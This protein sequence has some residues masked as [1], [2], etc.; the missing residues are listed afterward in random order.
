M[1]VTKVFSIP[2]F[3]QSLRA[4]RVLLIA[5]TVVLCL[6]TIVITYAGNLIAGTESTDYTDAQTDFYSHL[7]VL[8]AYNEMMGTDLS[9]EDFASS[10]DTT[11]YETVFEMMSAQSEDLD[12]SVEK[13]AESAELLSESDVGLDVYITNFEY[14]YALGATEGVFT[15]DTL[16]VSTMMTNMFEMMGMSSDMLTTMTEMDTSAMLNQMYFTIMCLLPII[17]FIIFAGNELFVDQ[18][19]KGSMA[20][21]L[22]TPTKR[23][24]VV[25]TQLIY[26]IITP[27]IMVGCGFLV[28][29]AAT[30]AFAGEVDIAKYAA[31]YGG[32]YLLAEAM[33]SIC[34][35]A[36]CVFN[37][38][39]NAMALG[40]GLNVWFFLCTLLGMF[41]S[42]T[43]VSMGIGAEMLGVFNNLTIVGLFDVEALGTVGSGAV[44]YAFVPKLIVLVAIAVVCYAVGAVRFQKKDLPL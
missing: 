21:V 33:A 14:V 13:F 43:M 3:K 42:E 17:L 9:Y 34:Y 30:Q 36:S 15:G 12:L 38:S 2:L 28:R 40:G 22:S 31:L 11:M 16:D 10:D 20:Y 44:D 4:N 41:G 32:I 24:A 27:L 26:M 37:L 5:C 6:M 19:D 8:A 23:S 39:K 35:M 29:L 25:I 7:Y 1:K 18:V